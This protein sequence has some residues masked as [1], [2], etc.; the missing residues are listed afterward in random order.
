[1]GA[2]R[3]SSI[4]KALRREHGELIA[5]VDEV[6]R[7]PLAGPVVA[8]AV[9]MPPDRRAI[10]GV[11]DS[12]RLSEPER[13][14]LA[15]RIRDTALAIGIGAAS[16]REIDTY[17]IYHASTRAI[18]RAIARLRLSPQHV[19]IDGLPIRTLGVTHT[20]VVRG[21]SRCYSVACAS[22]VAKVLRDSLMRR[23]ARRYPLYGWEHNAG[24]AT[25]EHIAMLDAQ[26]ASPHHRTSFRVTQFE[27]LLYDEAEQATALS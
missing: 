22:I 18:R 5:G 12:K 23:L 13:E 27:L 10:A 17:N 16:V 6:G 3:W 4:E 25:A 20:A 7:G 8:C 1:M 26:G 11:D 19:V 9:I 14:R 2:H 21:D 24:Y 15:V